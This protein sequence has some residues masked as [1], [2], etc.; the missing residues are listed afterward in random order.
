MYSSDAKKM[1]PEVD[2]MAKAVVSEVGLS[3][4]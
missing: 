1:L 4:K 2:K 3:V